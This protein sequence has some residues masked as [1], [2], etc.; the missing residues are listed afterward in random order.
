MCYFLN[1]TVILYNY[2]F[3]GQYFLGVGIEKGP[4]LKCIAIGRKIHFKI[5]PILLFRVNS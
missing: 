1:G 5:D 4:M 3:G 2:S